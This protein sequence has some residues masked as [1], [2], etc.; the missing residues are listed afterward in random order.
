[1]RVGRT[2]RVGITLPTFRDD[3]GAL[4]GARRAET[5]GLDGVFVFDHIWPLGRPDRPALSAF[6]VLGAVAAVTERVFL[7]PLVARVGLVPDEVLVSELRSLN[8]MAPGRLIAG[9]GTGDRRSA[10]ENISYGI[11]PAA[12][13]ERRVA[14]RKSARSLIDIGIP[15]WV[16]GGS[17]TTVELALELGSGAA[18]N[19]WE[20]QP[21]AL[22]ALVK[23]C[24]V[25]WGGPVDGAV[26]QIVQWL[27]E[28]EAA[29]ASWA[30][31]AWPRSL[32]V[33]SQAVELL[34]GG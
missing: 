22:A 29:G 25:T 12:A 23:R 1:M 28:L 30:V 10:V 7:G 26:E 5:L 21:S 18:V 31:C 17:T 13:H 27:S 6:P 2:V 9:L 19:L 34:R 20:A 3:A 24:D 32:E 15:V 4:D 14:L 8:A 11:P 16:G 33:L